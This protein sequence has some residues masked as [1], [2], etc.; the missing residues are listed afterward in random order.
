MSYSA[1]GMS[2]AFLHEALLYAGEEDFLARTVPFIAEGVERGEPIM[3]AVSRRKTEM[4]RWR[5]DGAADEVTFIEM[6]GLGRNPGRII[7]AWSAFA[8]ERGGEGRALRGIGEPVWPERT[9]EELVECHHHESLLNLT[10]ADAGPFTLLCPYDTVAL[11]DD[12][13]ETAWCTHPTV[14][15]NG[16][17]RP[18]DAYLDPL[19]TQG[20]YAGPLAPAP[21]AAREYFFTRDYLKDLREI[22]L[23]R[24]EDAGVTPM[25]AGDLVLAV[26]EAATNSAVHSGGGGML[27]IWE[28]GDAFVCEVRDGGTIRDPLAGRSR[29]EAAQD[30]GRG[31]YIVHQVCD[32]VQIRSGPE[33]TVVRLRMSLG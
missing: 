2:G 32:L 13:L 33:G 1:V 27:R 29:P 16:A 7:P 18:S 22:V 26:N 14:R 6:T 9:S 15:A 17:G 5:L 12:A 11:G 10:F 3:V 4:L 25:R 21:D 8:A 30:Y 31:L 19:A 20:P 23:H 24:A 28:E